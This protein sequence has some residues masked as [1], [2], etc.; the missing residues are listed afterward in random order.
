MKVRLPRGR[1]DDDVLAD[2]PVP[3]GAADRRL[4]REPAAGEVGLGRA[5]ERPGVGLA[6]VVE[7]LGGPA[8]REGVGAVVDLDHDRV[9]QPHPEALDLRLQVGLILLGDVVIGVLLEIAELPR[10]LDP[11][12]H[13]EPGRALELLDLRLQLREA[14]GGDRLAG[15]SLI[16]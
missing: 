9:P 5:D 13:L 11:G 3:E 6:A 12:R 4:G 2:A 14:L 1:L 15:H 10:R 7:D 16:V 8:E